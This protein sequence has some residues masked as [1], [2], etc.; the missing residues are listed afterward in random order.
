VPH[1]SEA[2]FSFNMFGIWRCPR[3]RLTQS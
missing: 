1:Y 3:H 2:T